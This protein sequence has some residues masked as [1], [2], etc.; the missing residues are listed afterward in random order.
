MSDH[1][2]SSDEDIKELLELIEVL[3]SNAYF[4]EVVPQFSEHFRL[5]REMTE[6][7]AKQYAN[8]EYYKL[9]EGDS[10]KVTPLKFKTVFLWFVANE[11]TSVREVSDRFDITKSTLFKIVGRVT[12]FFSNLPPGV[13]KWPNDLEKVEI[14]THFRNK[15][16][17][18]GIIDG[19]HIRI[20][21]PAEDPDSYSNRKHFYPIQAQVVCD[22][23]R[24]IRDIFVG[25]PGSVHDSRV[26]STSPLNKTL[27]EKC[28]GSVPISISFSLS[29]ADA[30]DGVFIVSDDKS[31]T[32]WIFFFVPEYYA[33]FQ[34]IQ[35]PFYPCLHALYDNPE[36][37]L[38]WFGIGSELHPRT[39]LLHSQFRCTHPFCNARTQAYHFSDLATL[40]PDAGVLVDFFQIVSKKFDAVYCISRKV[41]AGKV[42]NVTAATY[43]VQPTL[44]TTVQP[45][46]STS[47]PTDILTEQL[48]VT[49]A[50]DPVS[51]AETFGTILLEMVKQSPRR[52]QTKRQKVGTE[53]RCVR[54]T[55][56]QKAK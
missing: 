55:Y 4:E 1:L 18:V 38:D 34:P 41:F 40:A 19:T 39:K 6:E 42:L 17:I 15:H 26:L 30:S 32:G 35:T 37:V 23:K 52:E 48:T 13:I 14:E 9:Q 33:L 7:L 50:T 16:R 10:E 2:S 25:Y 22:H 21:K 49:A 28:D 27:P 56:E 47:G 44:T 5:T 12:H 51:S 29:S 11:A 53:K 3:K 36:L 43:P 8:S 24:R 46:P 54:V 31:K 45:Q 20:D